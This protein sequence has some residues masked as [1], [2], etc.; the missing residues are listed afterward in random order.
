MYPYPKLHIPNRDPTTT[1]IQSLALIE[2]KRTTVLFV[3]QYP[4]ELQPF[5]A[6]Y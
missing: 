1:Q 5:T 2:T 3:L 4:Y 6:Q